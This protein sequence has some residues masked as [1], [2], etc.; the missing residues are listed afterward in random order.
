MIRSIATFNGLLK[1]YAAETNP[2]QTIVELVITPFGPNKNKQGVKKSEASNI[3]RTCVNQ[4]I[5]INYETG[6]H[7][8][9]YPIGVITEAQETEAEIIGLGVLWP[10][11]YPEVTDYLKKR[12]AEN[13]PVATSWEILHEGSY[14]EDG[15]EW[16]TG[17]YYAANTIVENPSYPGKTLMK[18]IAEDLGITESEVQPIEEERTEIEN[19]MAML[20]ALYSTLDDLYYKTFEI[21]EAEMLQNTSDVSSFNTRLTDLVT[22]LTERANNAGVSLQEKEDTMSA[23]EAELHSVKA[24]LETLKTEKAEAALNA[25]VSKR[26]SALA[27]IDITLDETNKNTILEMTDTQFELFVSGIKQVKTKMSGKSTAEVK[28][29]LPDPVIQQSEITIDDIKEAHKALKKGK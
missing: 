26:E 24:E 27:E 21:E 12:T 1:A 14:V 6:K 25:K 7:K 23:M 29:N 17:C 3:L 28:I 10:E 18:C 4:P 16:L 15:I 2:L 11:E 9:S 8:D 20:S 13:N 5:K 22:K 19:L